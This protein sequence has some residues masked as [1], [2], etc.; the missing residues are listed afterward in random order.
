VAG[1]NHRTAK[2]PGILP[3]VFHAYWNKGRQ[4]RTRKIE[5]EG[6]EKDDKR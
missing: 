4:E 5:K 6:G 2:K 1:A 3:S